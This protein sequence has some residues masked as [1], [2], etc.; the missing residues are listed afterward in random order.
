MKIETDEHIF[1]CGMT[2][3]GK[4]VLMRQLFK[5]IPPGHGILLDVKHEH[6][7]MGAVF[8]NIRNAVKHLNTRRN[9]V[10]QPVHFD[11]DEFDQLADLV[12]FRYNTV[13]AVDEA[14]LVCPQG[15]LSMPYKRLIT[16]GRSRKATMWAISQ[17]PALIDKTIISQCRHYFA[18]ELFDDH[19]LKA[20]GGNVPGAQEKIPA[21]SKY[22]YLHYHVGDREAVV[23][24]PV[25]L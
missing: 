13:L 25:K 12:Y 19:D 8:Y 21:M 20:V 18:F 24:P 3:S 17:R 6:N 9:V 16:A 5:A 4:S 10:F 7:D 23:C 22:H 2:D 1:I 11:Q 14:Q 15:K